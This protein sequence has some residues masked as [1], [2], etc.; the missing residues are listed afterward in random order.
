MTDLDVS[1]WQPV[2]QPAETQLRHQAGQLTS[3]RGRRVVDAWIV[4]NL[5]HDKWFADLP[6][7]I[8]FDDGRRFEVSWQ[9]FDELSISWNSIDV[10]VTPIAWVT[11]PLQWRSQGHPALRNIVGCAV[12][13]VDATQHRF[14]THRVDAPGNTSAVWLTSGIWLE[15]TGAGLHLFNA[16]DENGLSE[17]LP[18]DGT[19]FRRAAI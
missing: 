1:G 3:L 13:T 9:K 10:A 15:T 17:D 8:E 16:L 12:R 6:V 14:T 18:V 11:W 5:E 2:W 7:V 19:E 4:W